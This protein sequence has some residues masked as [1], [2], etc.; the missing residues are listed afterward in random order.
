MVHIQLPGTHPVGVALEEDTH[1]VA[2]EAV[3]D[4]LGSEAYPAH[5]PDLLGT[6]VLHTVAVDRTAAGEA[7]RTAADRTVGS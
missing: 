2:A 5:S 1:M 6:V 7:A 3:L 4:N